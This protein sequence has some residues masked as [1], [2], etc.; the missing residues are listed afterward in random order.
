MQM[1]RVGWRC[2]QPGSAIVEWGAGDVRSDSD[3]A[4][5]IMAMCERLRGRYGISDLP[6]GSLE[7]AAA[8][9]Y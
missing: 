3:Y 5:R 2:S 1:P 8:A 6:M 9:M 7:L 4:C